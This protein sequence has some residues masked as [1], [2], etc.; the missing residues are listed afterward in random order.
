VP[1]LLCTVFVMAVEVDLCLCISTQ[2]ALY[3]IW[4]YDFLF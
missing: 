2:G 4:C 1:P 3:P